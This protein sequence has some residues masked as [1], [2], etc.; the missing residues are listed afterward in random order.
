[1]FDRMLVGVSDKATLRQAQCRLFDKLSAGSS[2]SSL[3]PSSVHRSAGS[4]T[5]SLRPSSVDRSADSLAR[6]LLHCTRRAQQC[7]IFR[8]VLYSLLTHVSQ[9]THGILRN[10]LLVLDCE[11]WVK[12]VDL[13]MTTRSDA[14]KPGPVRGT[15]RR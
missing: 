2:T 1:L 5:R 4:S 10:L 7:S 11:T 14:F 3:R 6:S 15:C 13:L 8:G 12:G 9:P